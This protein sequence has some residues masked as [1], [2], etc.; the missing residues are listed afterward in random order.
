MKRLMSAVVAF[1]VVLGTAYGQG[2]PLTGAQS[3]SKTIMGED[4]V[5]PTTGKAVVTSA[6]VVMAPGER[7]IAHRHGV[8]MFAYM[9]EGELTVDYGARGIRVYK[10]GEAILEAMNVSHFGRN[11]GAGTV[12]I[13]VVYMGAEGTKDVLPD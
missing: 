9:L 12:R 4:I 8:P 11:T 5:Y 3:S 6:I 10:Q 2:Y 1:A 13:L 7:T